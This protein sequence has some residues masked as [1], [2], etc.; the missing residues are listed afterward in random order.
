[1]NIIYYPVVKS[2]IFSRKRLVLLYSRAVNTGIPYDKRT[3]GEMESGI[4][5]RK[6]WI[7]GFLEFS[8]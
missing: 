5:S 1:M 2:N 3:V 6:D 7:D 4:I 8:A